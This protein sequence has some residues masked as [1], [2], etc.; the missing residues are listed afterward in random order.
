MSFL[1]TVHII[2]ISKPRDQAITSRLLTAP[3]TVHLTKLAYNTIAPD[4]YN[5]LAYMIFAACF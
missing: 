4:I 1:L 2:S 5:L 3:R